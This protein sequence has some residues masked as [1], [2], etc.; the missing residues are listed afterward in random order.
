MAVSIKDEDGNINLGAIADS[1]YLN[2]L[3]IF[4]CF[5]FPSQ[6]ILLLISYFD[7]NLDTEMSLLL[8]MKSSNV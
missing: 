6:L 7:Q 5:S 2:V 8:K 1:E 3:F 4:L